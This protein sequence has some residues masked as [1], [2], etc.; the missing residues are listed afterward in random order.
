[1]D[2]LK[3]KPKNIDSFENTE[4][5]VW[6]ARRFVLSQPDVDFFEENQQL[7]ALKLAFVLTAVIQQDDLCLLFSLSALHIATLWYI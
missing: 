7:L 2:G 3:V 6:A 5:R 1:M 4:N